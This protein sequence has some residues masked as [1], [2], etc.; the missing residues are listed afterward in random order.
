MTR[1]TMK[2]QWNR[3]FVQ[4]LMLVGVSLLSGCALW[5]MIQT[6]NSADAPLPTL[7]PRPL[8]LLHLSPRTHRLQQSLHRLYKRLPLCAKIMVALVP[9][10]LPTLFGSKTSRK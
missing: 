2:M 10:I 7:P 3:Q 4:A 5:E 8:T 9:T 6:Q 1:R